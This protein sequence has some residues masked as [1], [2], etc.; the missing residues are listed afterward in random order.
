MLSWIKFKNGCECGNFDSI[1]EFTCEA[2]GFSERLYLCT[3]C[4]PFLK[5]EEA[6]R[7]IKTCFDLAKLGI[8]KVC[9]K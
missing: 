7:Q 2:C 5:S 3:Y 1:F 4:N 9:F 8:N 6:E